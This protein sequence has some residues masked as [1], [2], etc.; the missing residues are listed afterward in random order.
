MSL[1][2]PKTAALGGLLKVLALAGILWPLPSQAADADSGARGS[3]QPIHSDKGFITFTRFSPSGNA[4]AYGRRFYEPPER[5]VALVD[6]ASGKELWR[7]ADEPKGLGLR[8]GVFSS[9]G[10]V[11]AVGSLDPST[12][13]LFDARRG[14]VLAELEAPFGTAVPL[15]FS[16]DS[17]LLVGLTQPYKQEDVARRKSARPLVVFWDTV[18]GKQARTLE[19]EYNLPPSAHTHDIRPR[20]EKWPRALLKAAAFSEDGKTLITEHDGSL[21][22]T[23][24]SIERWDVATGKSLGN[25]RDPRYDGLR[26]DARAFVRRWG[27]FGWS[28]VSLDPAPSGCSSV[29]GVY[30][31]RSFPDDSVQVLPYSRKPPVSVWTQKDGLL[32]LVEPVPGVTIV[33]PFGTVGGQ[34]TEERELCRFDDF[35]GG[36]LRWVEL[37]SDGKYL[38][39]LGDKENEQASTCWSGTSPGSTRPSARWPWRTGIWSGSG[40]S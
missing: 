3:P 25:W 16:P 9:D 7:V 20:S 18:T 1:K 5:R 17:K 37:S 36:R 29:F 13:C 26:P 2:R 28:S 19:I 8:E 34:K 4:L 33:H 38:L 10:A 23:T 22:F 30:R 27:G 12:A 32:S 15:A 31:V 21:G 6:L 40:R 39:A 35:R 11:L 24:A 14:K